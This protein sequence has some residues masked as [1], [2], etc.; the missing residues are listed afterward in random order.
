[1]ETNHTNENLLE[2]INRIRT[3]MSAQSLT[4]ASVMAEI[5]RKYVETA[6]DAILNDRLDKLVKSVAEQDSREKR[7]IVVVIGESGAGKTTMIEH[8]CK[9]R[10]EFQPYLD[11]HGILT[12]PLIQF[13]APSPCTPKMIAIRGL[14]T[15]G[16]PIASEIKETKA[17]DL[18]RHQLRLRKVI[19]V[20]ID[21]AQH[22]V[23]NNDLSVVQKVSDSFK[24]LVQMPEWPVRLILS[25]VSP[26]ERTV[27]D[28]K[29]IRSRSMPI[30]L[31]SIEAT[32]DLELVKTIVETIT[33]THAQLDLDDFVD[34]D[35]VR[36]LVHSCN[37]SFGSIIQTIRAAVEMVFVEGNGRKRLK[38]GDFAKAYQ[39]FSGCVASENIFTK[40]DWELLD[41]A[42]AIMRGSQPTTLKARPP[43][44]S[45]FRYGERP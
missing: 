12:K 41:P 1:M 19:F 43:R 15:L 27:L 10:T 34:S 25:G 26:L 5:N 8:N 30:T 9:R 21:E 20:H 11:G 7:R 39:A 18:F 28:D 17:W 40:A 16:Y 3:S 37:G 32:R 45:A 24:D 6:R 33:K 36:R 44:K 29:Q 42:T 14:Q 23:M 2:A 35:F 31:A 22:A 4:R 38:L 13:N